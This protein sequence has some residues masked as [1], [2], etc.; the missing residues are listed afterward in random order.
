MSQEDAA[1]TCLS[2]G[3]MP[4]VSDVLCRTVLLFQTPSPTVTPGGTTGICQNQ[5]G[6]SRS[7]PEMELSSAPR[8]VPKLAGASEHCLWCLLSTRV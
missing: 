6:Y 8:Q 1:A 7:N 3:L 5:E 4:A 2:M